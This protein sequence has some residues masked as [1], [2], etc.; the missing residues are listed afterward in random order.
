ML[1]LLSSFSRCSISPKIF[2]N[3]LHTSNQLN[4]KYTPVLYG[5]PLKKKRKMD[6]A[7]VKA[8]E[9][10]KRKKL[11]KQIRRLEKN[12]RQLKPIDDL[13]T[14]LVLI[15]EKQM[16]TRELPVLSEKE[17]EYRALLLKKWSKYR[18]EENLK[19]LKILDRMVS[20]QRKAL[21]ELRFESEELYQQAIQHDLEMVPI[22]ING[23]VA[24]PPIKNYEFVDGDY[25]DAT[26]V[27]EGEVVEPKK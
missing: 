10:R 26:K 14:P 19:N 3:N 22:V 13:E 15:D 1:K 21:D 27:Y 20:A 16:R 8:R 25:I 6:P 4:F 12:S 23:P 17:Q 11:E 18:N 9:D 2:A 5:E 7:V 24:T